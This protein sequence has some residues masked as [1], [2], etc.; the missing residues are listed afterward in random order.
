MSAG[1]WIVATGGAL[2]LAIVLWPADGTRWSLRARGVRRHRVRL[3]VE[4]PAGAAIG[5][6][7]LV[8][9]LSAVHAAAATVGAVVCTSAIKVLV[10]SRRRMATAEGVARLAGVLA[11]QASVAVT[12]S[13]AVAKAAPLV[14]GPVGA[15]AVAMAEDC[16]VLGVEAAA[17]RF[18]ARVPS[19]VAGSLADLV[20]VAAEGGGRWARTVE[21][22]EAE[23]SQAAASARLFHGR[24]A[25]AM[26]TLALVVVL[27]AGLI[28]AAG[29]VATD[30]G[31]WLTGRQGAALLLTG[32]TV[33][34]V[35]SARVLLSARTVA[36][37]EG[38]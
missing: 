22:L 18:A 34:A 11:N 16:E 2:V 7:V 30:V 36:G 38:S 15:A 19:A 3:P 25:A 32:A 17:R 37:A 8:S 10:A 5:A 13:D 1:G 12:V 21:V 4:L 28:G 14:S 35:L 29:L 24:V 33:I 26:P 23:A 27:G 9:G 20:A 6:L 31:E